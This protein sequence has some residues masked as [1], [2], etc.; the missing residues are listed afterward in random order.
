[1]WVAVFNIYNMRGNGTLILLVVLLL[2]YGLRMPQS[3]K[4]NIVTSCDKPLIRKCHT[5][6]PRHCCYHRYSERSKAAGGILSCFA[7]KLALRG[8]SV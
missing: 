4:G 7:T 6:S 5:R 3:C 8:S 1:M 2:Q